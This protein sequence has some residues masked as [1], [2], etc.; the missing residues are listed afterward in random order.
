[1]KEQLRPKSGGVGET[2]WVGA[3]QRRRPEGG[4]DQLKNYKLCRRK[5]VSSYFPLSSK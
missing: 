2:E 4:P 3:A 1:M 5:G